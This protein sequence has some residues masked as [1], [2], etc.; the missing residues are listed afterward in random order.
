M[1]KY[2][3]LGRNTNAG[4]K[5]KID[6]LAYCFFHAEGAISQ[7]KNKEYVAALKEYQGNI[8]LVGINYEKKNMKH[9]C[10]I[11]KFEL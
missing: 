7:I 2:R 6:L 11:E 10:R 3:V 5:P 8:L 9:E 1:L 4:T